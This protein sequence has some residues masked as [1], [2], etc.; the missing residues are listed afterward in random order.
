M[1]LCP[2]LSER[3]LV[4]K[5]GAGVLSQSRHRILLRRSHH[6]VDEEHATFSS[7]GFCI[8]GSRLASSCSAID[9]GRSEGV[10]ETAVT[11]IA[12]WRHLVGRICRMERRKASVI[13][14]GHTVM[15]LKLCLV[16]CRCGKIAKHLFPRGT[17]VGGGRRGLARD[18]VLSRAIFAWHNDR[19]EDTALFFDEQGDEGAGQIQ[20]GREHNAD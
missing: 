5:A 13:L 14:L 9:S 7:S 3:K 1:E 20:S 15:R 8:S 4:L 19:S 16:I 2:A 18:D 17:E 12:L 11:T 10:V 6:V